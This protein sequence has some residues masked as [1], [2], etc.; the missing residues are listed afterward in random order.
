MV[1]TFNFQDGTTPPKHTIENV[2]TTEKEISTA[3]NDTNTVDL[4]SYKLMSVISLI[5]TSLLVRNRKE[6]ARG[7]LFFYC[8]NRIVVASGLRQ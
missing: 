5:A 2:K 8:F 7:E 1:I 6:S 4:S 3:L